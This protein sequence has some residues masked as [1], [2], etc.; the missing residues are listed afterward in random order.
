M[1]EH[2]RLY[3][4]DS[5]CPHI[6]EIGSL[7]K[8]AEYLSIMF[9]CILYF[10]VFPLQDINTELHRLIV[11]ILFVLKQAKK[12]KLKDELSNFSSHYKIN[13]IL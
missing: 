2:L 4:L 3:A 1:D 8:I 13:A 5:F 12:E 9:S 11:N 6:K 7:D 10:A